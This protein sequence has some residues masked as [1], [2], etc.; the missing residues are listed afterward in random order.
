TNFFEEKILQEGEKDFNLIVMY[1]KDAYWADVV[2]ACRRFPMFAEK[3]VVILKDAAQMRTLNELAAYLETPSPTTVFLIEHRF[4]KADGRG[5][6]V[7]LSKEKGFYFTSEKIK[8]EQVPNWIKN[9][10]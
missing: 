10:G 6:L 9:H 7:K 3:Q 8:E 5:K 2:N 4:K 1:G